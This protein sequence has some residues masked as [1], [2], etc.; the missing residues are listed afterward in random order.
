M[1][2]NIL[3]FKNSPL[4]PTSLKLLSKGSNLAGEA[5]QKKFSKDGDND[6]VLVCG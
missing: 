2:A 5:F 6:T 3:P 1:F 4:A